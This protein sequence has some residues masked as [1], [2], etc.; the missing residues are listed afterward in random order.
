V[1]EVTTNESSPYTPSAAMNSVS[2]ANS[3]L[4][5]KYQGFERC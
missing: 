2:L 4:R 1:R 3:K 5:L